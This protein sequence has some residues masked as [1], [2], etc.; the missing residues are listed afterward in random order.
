MLTTLAGYG[1]SHAVSLSSRS[2]HFRR[3]PFHRDNNQPVLQQ[4]TERSSAIPGWEGVNNARQ[5]EKPIHVIRI[6]FQRH[7]A[8]RRQSAGRNRRRVQR[9]TTSAFYGMRL[10]QPKTFDSKLHCSGSLP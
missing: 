3:W 7:A 2:S 4:K 8:R 9:S 10:E 5:V 1:T 6:R